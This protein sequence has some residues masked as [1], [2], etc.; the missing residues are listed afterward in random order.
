MHGTRTA[1]LAK[2]LENTFR[3]VNIAL[4]NELATVADSLH[5]NVWEAV[6]AASTKPFGYLPFLPGPGVGG[7]C[8]TTDPVYLA[9]Q[10][11][12]NAGQGL[13]LVELANE[14]NRAMPQYVAHRIIS[15]LGMRGISINGSRILLLGLAYKK[16]SSDMRDSPA[17]DIAQHLLAAGAQVRAAEPIA[18]PEAIPTEM[19]LVTP[20]EARDFRG[21]CGRNPY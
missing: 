13:R 19:P 7:H 18:P 17:L 4:I 5:A 20:T 2:L 15:G 12:Q 10:V 9:W 3:Q 8:L 6:S 1:E 14:V 16:N 21:G 11:R